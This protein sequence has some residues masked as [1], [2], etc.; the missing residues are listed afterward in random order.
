MATL[1]PIKATR[2]GEDSWADVD[3][4]P[5]DVM[6]AESRFK[7]FALHALRTETLSL[8]NVYRVA[9]CAMRRA[10]MISAELAFA[11]F[12]SSWDVWTGSTADLV[13]DVEDDE[14]STDAVD[15]TSPAA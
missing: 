12:A 9:W 2:A 1:L 13:D 5:R 3:V 11:E 8:T 10:G 7:D 15:P 14:S 4:T 6:A